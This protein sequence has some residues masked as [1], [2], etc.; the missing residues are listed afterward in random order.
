MSSQDIESSLHCWTLVDKSVGKGIDDHK[1][2]T[3]EGERRTYT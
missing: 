2:G 3:D 1:A